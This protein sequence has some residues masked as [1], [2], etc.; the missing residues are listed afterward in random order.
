MALKLD[1]T[2]KTMLPAATIINL[3]ITVWILKTR[4]L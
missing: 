3:L 1:S 4:H 2:R